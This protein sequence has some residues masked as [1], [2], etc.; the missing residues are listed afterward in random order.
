MEYQVFSTRHLEATTGMFTF[1]CAVVC[2]ESVLSAFHTDRCHLWLVLVSRLCEVA[3]VRWILCITYVALKFC[4]ARRLRTLRALLQKPPYVVA[5]VELLSFAFIWFIYHYDTINRGNALLCVFLVRYSVLDDT[6]GCF[7]FHY[8]VVL[9]VRWNCGG[10]PNCELWP[11]LVTVQWSES[12][13]VNSLQTL[14]WEIGDTSRSWNKY[15][16]KNKTSNDYGMKINSKKTK[17]MSGP[18][19]CVF[20]HKV[21][22]CVDLS[23][24]QL[25][26][27][28][29]VMWSSKMQWKFLTEMISYLRNIPGVP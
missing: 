11:R 4:Y 9:A 8:I 25:T 19:N 1:F 6:E 28:E 13:H 20:W 10:R 15:L 16:N 18:E 27:L 3:C 5:V 26:L 2:A 7:V 22:S 21:C 12:W 14:C 17:V 24:V 23:S 29:C